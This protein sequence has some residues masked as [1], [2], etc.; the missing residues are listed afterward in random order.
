M[1]RN[2][3]LL[4]TKYAPPYFK[5]GMRVLEIAPDDFPSV[6]WPAS[7]AVRQPVGRRTS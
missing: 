7:E 2:S 4:F 1:H 3:R 6:E 5:D